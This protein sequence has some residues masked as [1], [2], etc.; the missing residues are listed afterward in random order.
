MAAL[1]LAPTHSALARPHKLLVH[2]AAQASELKAR[3]ARLL[4]DYG[5]FQLLE[6][7]DALLAAPGLSR[8]ELAD[9]LD[10]IELNAGR[11]DTR[12]PGVMAQRRAVAPAAGNRLHLVQFAGPIKPEWREALEQ[13][14]VRVVHY[15]PQNAYLISGDSAALA[16]LQAWADANPLVQWD[17]EYAADYQI[18]P[19]AR[20]V[21][22]QGNPQ[23][24]ATDTF[25]VQLVDDAEANPATLAL[26]DQL[27]LAPVQRQSRTLHYLNVVVRLPA[28]RLGEL[29]AQPEVISIQPRPKRHKMDERQDQ[30]MAGNLSGNAPSGPGY[31]AW[32]AG[33]GF[34]QAQFTASGF[35]VDVSDSGIDNGTTAPGH[36]GLYE[37]GDPGRAAA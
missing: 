9:D 28:D 5:S 21:D 8:V 10:F 34:T 1:A 6:T 25:T 33:K 35:V 14:G 29:A 7:D 16:T 22:P 2:D 23:T 4:A 26:I 20:T 37:A 32:L 18:H 11:L 15:V 30:I 36:F 19:K 13:T 17:G 12:A 31:L 27:K 3:G 24:L